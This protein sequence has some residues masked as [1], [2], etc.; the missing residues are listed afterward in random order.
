MKSCEVALH[1]ITDDEPMEKDAAAQGSAETSAI[2]GAQD[3][4]RRLYRALTAG[5]DDLFDV[6]HDQA[7]EVIANLLKNPALDE[8][9]LLALLKKRE[10][11]EEIIHAIYR[12]EVAEGSHRVK[13]A[14][15]HNP[16][17]PTPVRLAVIPHLYLF[18]LVTICSLPGVTADQR[19]AAERA[20]IQRLPTTPLGN[21]ITLARRGTAS[22]VAELL[23]MEAGNPMIVEAC[24]S[25]PHLKESAVFQFLSSGTGTAETVSMVGRH[26]RW[27]LRPNLQMAMLKNSHTPMVW[28]ALWLPRLKTPD[29]QKLLVSGRL[30]SVQRQEVESEIAKRRR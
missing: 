27:K 4:N 23:R 26:E 29:L 9:H 3:L 5:K 21:K 30:N 16:S 22:L 19:L 20:I 1:S 28:F 18:E 12:H 17:T 10:L 8:N 6:V 2:G 15:V 14:L 7:P 25:N 13:V 11:S 24:L